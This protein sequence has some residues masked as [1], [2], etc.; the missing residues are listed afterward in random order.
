MLQKNAEKIFTV[1]FVNETERLNRTI[2]VYGDEYILD[3]AEEQ[4]IQL[5]YACRAG[6]CVACIG[7]VIKGS[8]DQSDHSFLKEK[9]LKAGFVLTCKAYPLSNCVIL[10]HQEEAL[11]EL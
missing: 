5:P 11:F 7:K 4:D 2:E 1:T 10:T 3:A 8:V 9:E 6:A